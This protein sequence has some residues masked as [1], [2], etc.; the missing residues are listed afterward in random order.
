ML[1]TSACVAIALVWL[2]DLVRHDPI[3]SLTHGG[4]L[5]L[6]LWLALPLPRFAR[7]VLGLS[8]GLLIAATT[9]GAVKGETRCEE[10]GH[11]DC[12]TDE[13][14]RYWVPVVLDRFG[15]Q[16]F[17]DLRNAD[18][19]GVDL[20]FKELRYADFSNADLSGADL[21]DAYMRRARLDRIDA[22]GSSWNRAYLD[23]ATM[24]AARLRGSDLRGIHAYR[25]DLQEAD[26]TGA[27]ASG[28]SLSH[29]NFKLG[30][31]LRLNLSG[32]YLRFSENLVP[33][34]LAQACGDSATRLPPGFTI[35]PCR[36]STRSE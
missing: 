20:R 36:G 5:T 34:Q 7:S 24:S 30:N 18:L 22:V 32:T 16:P 14:L 11:V 21:S 29:A 28:A 13:G 12:L 9:Y 31:L 1:K 15:L 33:E 35:A 23:G 3:L 4:I 10:G 8:A 6:A 25:V 17:A 2:Q 27:D 19:R 26:L